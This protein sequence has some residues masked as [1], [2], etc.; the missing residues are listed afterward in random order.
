MPTLTVEETF[1]FAF[2]SMTGGTHRMETGETEASLTDEQK[3]LVEWMDNRY[4]KV[5]L[6]C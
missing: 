2:D 1:K 4:F 5:C 3:A 6:S